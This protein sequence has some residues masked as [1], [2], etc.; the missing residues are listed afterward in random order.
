MDPHSYYLPGHSLALS[1]MITRQTSYLR[2]HLWVNGLWGSVLSVDLPGLRDE[3]TSQTPSTGTP[4]MGKARAILPHNIS[5]KSPSRLHTSSYGFLLATVYLH[6]LGQ[7][8][9]LAG[10]QTAASC[11]NGCN[12]AGRSPQSNGSWDFHTALF[13]WPLGRVNLSTLTP[14]LPEWVL[15]LP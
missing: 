5:Q 6:D 1:G 8:I 10:L 4:G 13:T 14:A 12:G 2:I 7:G 11:S 3:S 9:F 15:N